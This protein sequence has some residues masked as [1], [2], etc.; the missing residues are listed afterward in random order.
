MGLRLRPCPI[1]SNRYR[2]FQV[3]F[4]LFGLPFYQWVP[5]SRLR[6]SPLEWEV[7]VEVVVGGAGVRKGV[8]SSR[9]VARDHMPGP[10]PGGSAGRKHARRRKA[11]IRWWWWG[12]CSR[13][14]GS[15]SSHSRSPPRGISP[16]N[17][18]PAGGTI[19][20]FGGLGSPCHWCWCLEDV[21]SD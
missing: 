11:E 5:E 9:A 6:A 16:D 21:G 1:N 7:G 17:W 18:S 10:L 19:S 15:C 4:H 12:L 8:R 20:P 2:D 14:Y 13:P 3:E